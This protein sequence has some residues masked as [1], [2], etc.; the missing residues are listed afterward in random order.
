MRKIS[1]I[2]I[3]WGKNDRGVY[4]AYPWPSNIQFVPS[5]SVV[6]L[7]VFLPFSS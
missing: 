4:T 7:P 2:L 1:G 3:L 6:S 5:V